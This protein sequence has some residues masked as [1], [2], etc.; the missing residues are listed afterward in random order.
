MSAATATKPA[1]EKPAQQEKIA[2]PK[3]PDEDAFKKA[4]AE[5]QKEHDALKAK[6]VRIF[7]PLIRG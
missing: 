6:L 2:P 5:K 1:A 7:S 4:L 3:K